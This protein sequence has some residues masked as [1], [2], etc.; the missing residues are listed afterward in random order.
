VLESIGYGKPPPFTRR[1][2]D[3]LGMLSPEE[4]PTFKIITKNVPK[5]KAGSN[6]CGLFCIKNVEMILNDP[7]SFIENAEEG[8]S[9]ENWYLPASASIKRDHLAES[10]QLM[11]ADQRLPGGQMHN[12]Q[13]RIPLPE[14]AIAYAK[15]LD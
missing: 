13:V 10:I 11:A 9:L 8:G 14:P 4:V 5:Q 6:D 2:C 15:S 12:S 1:F 3:Y 7:V